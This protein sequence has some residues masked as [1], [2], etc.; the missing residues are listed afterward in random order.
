MRFWIKM[1]A[2]SFVGYL[3]CYA[4]MLVQDR[5][6]QHVVVQDVES[7]TRAI[8]TSDLSAGRREEARAE[9]LDAKIRLDRVESRWQR[10]ASR[11]MLLSSAQ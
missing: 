1:G 11:L 9:L 7:I 10:D 5:R 4:S 2:L 6:E 3:A 8:A